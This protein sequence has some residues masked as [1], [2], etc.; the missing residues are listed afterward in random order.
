[1]ST[2]AGSLTSLPDAVPATSAPPRKQRSMLIDIVRGMA[3][4]L[5]ALGHT[6]QGVSAR[7]WWGA[8]HVGRQLNDS[9]YAFH[10]PA[11][12]FISGVFLCASVE[13]RGERSFL[14]DKLR[15]MIW[16]YLLWSVIS[17]LLT[18]PFAHFMRQTTPT[19]SEFFLHLVT[20][21]FFWFLPTLFFALAVATFTRRVPLPLLFVLAAIVSLVWPITTINFA[22]R[23]FAHLPFLVLGMWVGREYERI[24]AVPQWFAALLG[25]ALAVGI[26]AITSAPYAKSKFLF[27]PLGIAGTLM[28]LLWAHCLGRGWIARKLAWAGEASFGIFL[29]SA[30]PQGG[31]REILLH[32]H[33][34]TN[35]VLQDLFP[36]LLAICLPAWLYQHRVRFHIEWMF[37]WPVAPSRRPEARPSPKIARTPPERLQ[38]APDPSPDPRG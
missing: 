3:I 1:M 5:V 8:S 2:T 7:G 27:I 16:P 14:L 10:M 31:G 25:L 30:L 33:H 21:Q 38:S 4:S 17:T 20:A 9:I 6:N 19:F 28:L 15:T 22:D 34:T 36:T 18:I 24:E 12:F 11:F 13:K 32:L 23:G 26:V 35:P 29:L 37:I